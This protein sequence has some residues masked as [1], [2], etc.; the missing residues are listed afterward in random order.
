MKKALCLL[1]IFISSHTY[2]QTE[3]TIHLNSDVEVD[4]VSVTGMNLSNKLKS[5]FR[6]GIQE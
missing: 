2:G 6:D 1:I 4:S 3:F 5:G